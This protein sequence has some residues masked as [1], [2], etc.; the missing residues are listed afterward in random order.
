M[1]TYQFVV[2]F[3]SNVISGAAFKLLC[4]HHHSERDAQTCI[5]G[6]NEAN[7]S[8]YPY[9]VSLLSSYLKD[10]LLPNRHFCSGSLINPDMVLSAA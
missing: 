3:I 1:K 9:V 10:A 4:G 2:L 5:I 8:K 6:R 7:I